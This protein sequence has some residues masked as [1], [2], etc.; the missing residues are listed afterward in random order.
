[1]HVVGLNSKMPNSLVAAC[2]A[3]VIV[4][5]STFGFLISPTF[6][7]IHHFHCFASLARP[8]TFF[9]LFLLCSRKCNID[10]GFFFV[11]LFVVHYCSDMI[12]L[13]LVRWPVI[14]LSMQ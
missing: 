7:V 12:E 9:A 8:C 14:V 11:F 4:I 3:F 2:F 5:I 13:A 10:N 1:M 6:F